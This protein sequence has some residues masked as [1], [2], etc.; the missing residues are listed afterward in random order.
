MQS[1]ATPTVTAAPVVPP[2]PV[3]TVPD[4][5]VTAPAGAPAVFDLPAAVPALVPESV[6]LIQPNETPTT[7]VTTDDGKGQVQPT[8][9]QI[10]FTPSPT[11]IGDPAPLTFVAERTD[12]TAATGRDRRSPNWHPGLPRFWLNPGLTC[13]C[14]RRLHLHL[15]FPR[16]RVREPGRS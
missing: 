2:A 11:L 15:V 8:T 6:V 14:R 5:V 12:G 7:V 4:V 13:F 1:T 10:T 9:G 16:R 3:V